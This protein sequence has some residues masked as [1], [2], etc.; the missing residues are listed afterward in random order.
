M[1]EDKYN[2]LDELKRALLVLQ[3]GNNLAMNYLDLLE[4]EYFDELDGFPSVKGDFW[5]STE[6]QE[7]PYVLNIINLL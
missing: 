3:N 2:R 5:G 6:Q 4:S 7:S 1:S